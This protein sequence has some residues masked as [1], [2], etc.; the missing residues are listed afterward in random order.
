M[1]YCASEAGLT[2][3]EAVEAGGAFDRIAY[4]K[5][6]TSHYRKE[7]GF[8]T[9][10]GRAEIYSTVWRRNGY[11]PLPSY[12]ELP[13]SPY[14]DPELMKEYPFVVITGGRL[15]NYFHSQHRQVATLRR[16]HPEPQ[17]QIHPEAAARLGIK[18]G[19]WVCVESPRGRCVQRARL[20]SG[21]D[22][23][24]LHVE[25]GWWFPEEEGGTPHLYGVFRSNANTLTPNADPFLDPAFGGYTLR[26]FAAKAYKVTEEQATRIAWEEAREAREETLTP[27]AR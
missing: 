6:E 26:G 4:R 5:H 27:S 24:L 16:L 14:S 23:R 3:R 9:A 12:T 1:R 2:W 22:P 15:P 18:K 17:T 21:M 7:G 19:D 11:D 25:H 8:P 10:T 13:E 20:F